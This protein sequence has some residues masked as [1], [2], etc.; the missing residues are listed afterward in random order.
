[1]AWPERGVYYMC[2]IVG[3]TGSR[4]AAAL[5]LDGLKKLEYRGY[6]SA[7]LA[8]QQN[9]KLFIAK[10]A[11][12]V[13]DLEASLDPNLDQAT[14]GIG[15]T[16]W[17]THG[18]P[19]DINA[20]P[21]CSC[22]NE[23]ALVHNGIIEN[24]QELKE[25]LATEKGHHFV[26]ETDTEVLAHLI[27]EY[28]DGDL[29][30]AL[31]KAMEKVVG[32]YTVLAVSSREPGRLVCTRQ[33]SPL[34]IGLG[35]NENLVAS[36][37]TAL[38]EHTRKTKI[39]ED[40]EFAAVTAD[41]VEIIDA[42]GNVI[43]RDIFKVTW[44]LEAA[45][46]GGF[47]HFMLK[48]IMEQ[49]DAVR[50]TMRQRID[51][52]SG[53]VKLEDL[54]FS[55][56]ELETVEKFYIIACGTAYHA[57]LVGKN[58]IESLTGIPV[59]VDVASEFRY[60]EP[61]LKKNQMVIVISQSGETA[62]TLAAL[63]LARQNSLKVLAITNV[64][65][66]SVSR[67][68]DH[69]FYTWAG[70]EIA[71]ASTKAYLTQLVALYLFA[72][73][74]GQVRKSIKPAI[75]GQLI[76]G[77]IAL[78]G[79]LKTILAAD[80]IDH[81]KKYC[82]HLAGWD[83]AFFIGRNLDYPVAMEGA[84]KLKE[85]SYIHAEAYAAGELKHG[86]LALIVEGIPVIALATQKAVL[87]KTLSN[88]QEVNARGGAVFAITQEGFADVVRQVDAVFYLPPVNDLLAPVL[89]AVPTQLIAYYAA[90]EHGHSVDKPRNL[91]KSVTVE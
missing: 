68:A 81:L 37:I 60:R 3:Y 40:G 29:L 17:A 33:S 22:G 63:R 43:K 36:D 9:G 58:V 5:L 89:S 19:T 59:E 85:I 14:V 4:A 34:I 7:G 62:D 38:L 32:S 71:V 28:Y 75:A 86:P 64:V 27:E 82:H 57:G 88:I 20:H 30:E 54:G 23:I 74:L 55:A 26:S 35:E 44:D 79:Q 53:K 6:D 18:R 56:E 61:L 66:S 31:R 67:E 50:E 2:G 52:S 42:D 83:S 78:P 25:W 76:E 45:E 13:A 21:H 70:P 48:E 39:L 24:H 12:S 72:L 91:A 51:R 69:V 15:H 41:A 90:V 84:L 49:P 87:D 8:L 46:K 80:S 65:G 73:Y 77:L 11:G 47:D 1:M 16:R 10:R